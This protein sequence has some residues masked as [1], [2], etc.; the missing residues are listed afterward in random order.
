MSDADQ[1]GPV[2]PAAD[3]GPADPGPADPSSAY[4]G[5]AYPAP[6]QDY[7]APGPGY[8]APGPAY[9]AP[10]QGNPPPTPA[11]PGSG[12]SHQGPI[13]DAPTA[14]VPVPTPTAALP[15]P[16]VAVPPPPTAAQVGDRPGYTTK[17]GIVPLRP[18]GVGE[19]LD[20]AFRAFRRSQGSLLAISL[21][22]N[23]IAAI[24]TT[25][26]ALI[27]TSRLLVIDGDE[28][29]LGKDWA[30]GAL[31][32]GG[33]AIVSLLVSVT[34]P[35]FVSHAVGEAVLGRTVTLSQI[36]A[37]ARGKLG[38]AILLVLLLAASWLVAMV[39][40]ALIA[41]VKQLEGL[42]VLLILVL[43]VVGVWVYVR[44]TFATPAL[45]LED[46]RVM[47]AI[48]RSMT[49]TKGRWW[50]T[51]G[52]LLLSGIVIS[53]INQVLEVGLGFASGV[54]IGL[55]MPASS[56]TA[57][58]VAEVLAALLASAVTAPFVS[59]VISLLYI[60]ARIRSEG[61]DQVLLRA[62]NPGW[63]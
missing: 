6:G 11:Y 63:H 12:P 21:I 42:A 9:P 55:T 17:P 14:P 25:I 18:L 32:L 31:A 38:R 37:A 62:T 60:D 24:P 39:V 10:G 61:F 36:W 56:P 23:L 2:G 4:P 28:V 34:L 35:V 3:S 45:V 7:P 19:I 47:A 59:G 30:V 5:S 16:P 57:T 22:V 29:T 41:S 26:L 27:G 54:V 53:I 44:L 52:V 1:S 49:L 50:R 48:R 33:V 43:F 15:T 58:L 51:L 40:I 8:P 20:G 13:T 46:L